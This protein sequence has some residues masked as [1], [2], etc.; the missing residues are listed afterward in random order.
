VI[1]EVL[2]VVC[3][4]AGVLIAGFSLYAIDGW[5]AVGLFTALCLMGLAG[6]LGNRPDKPL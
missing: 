1:A 3:G 6:L 5:P 2:S 4:L